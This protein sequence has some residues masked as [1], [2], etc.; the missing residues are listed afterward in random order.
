MRAVLKGISPND[1]LSWEE[2]RRYSSPDPWDDFG[3]F[4]LDVGA[5]DEDGTN[6]FQVL[7]STPA[8]V[9]RAI[10]DAG[11]FQG[12]LVDRFDADEIQRV[13]RDR[14]AS[15]RCHTWNDIVEELRTFSL[16]EYEGM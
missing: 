4:T 2:F 11:E 3:W 12:I 15:I 16:W 9:S 10:G 1:F 14:I 13:L 8:V 7:V 5:D 6:L